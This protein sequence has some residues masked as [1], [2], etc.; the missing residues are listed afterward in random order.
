MTN[1]KT[2]YMLSVDS[3]TGIY[4]LGERKLRTRKQIEA[5]IKRAV[6]DQRVGDGY[7]ERGQ[8]LLYFTAM[9]LFRAAESR[10]GVG[11]HRFN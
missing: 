5:V 7:T 1:A 4:W 3:E 11:Y 8:S 10:F 6:V 9:R 2:N